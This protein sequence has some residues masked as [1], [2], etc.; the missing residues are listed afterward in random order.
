MKKEKLTKL[1][2]KKLGYCFEVET[3]DETQCDA[4]LCLNCQLNNNTLLEIYIYEGW[5]IPY[6]FEFLIWRKYPLEELKLNDNYSA[7]TVAKLIKSIKE[8]Y[9]RLKREFK[10][11]EIKEAC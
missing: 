3:C 8:Q 4:F 11:F 1:L 2:K 9:S 6:W 5:D 10:Y 7:E